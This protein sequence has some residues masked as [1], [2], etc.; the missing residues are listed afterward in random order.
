MV[1]NPN[2][3]ANGI[4]RSNRPQSL[5]LQLD[6][7]GSGSIQQFPEGRRDPAIPQ[8]LFTPP[9]SPGSGRLISTSQRN[10]EDSLQEEQQAI[11]GTE[12]APLEDS[13]MNA[14][15]PSETKVPL[16]VDYVPYHNDFDYEGLNVTGFDLSNLP[17]FP[18]R[19]YLYRCAFPLFVNKTLYQD[20]GIRDDSPLGAHFQLALTHGKSSPW[21]DYP[22]LQRPRGTRALREV[23]T[24]VWWDFAMMIRRYFHG[25][26]ASYITTESPYLLLPCT[27]FTSYGD[28]E[29]EFLSR[30]DSD[31]LFMK[32]ME[33][34]I[35]GTVSEVV[36]VMDNL[37]LDAPLV[38]GLKFQRQQVLSGEGNEKERWGVL[39][40]P[41]NIFSA[42]PLAV[43]C[44]PPWYL[45]KI[46]FDKVISK[47]VFATSPSGI[48]VLDTLDT[49]ETQVAGTS[50]LASN[51]RV[52]RDPDH[53][54]KKIWAVINDVCQNKGRFFILTNY[55]RWAFGQF[56]EDWTSVVISES[57]EPRLMQ[58]E[59]QGEFPGL[60]RGVTVPEAI[61]FWIQM[62][63]GTVAS[64]MI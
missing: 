24:Y 26:P 21:P 32:M 64:T 23:R 59:N 54:I 61:A 1:S 14:D 17:G 47:H 62:A 29:I 2:V 20:C 27:G 28:S 60:E 39:T 7:P 42:V 12:G 37:P 25:L 52:D 53:A 18:V 48:N 44:C 31:E 45:E 6:R 43:V 3:P 41:P 9:V 10:D 57:I 58:I 38:K 40:L 33:E 22:E 16:D 13:D 56:S 8:P 5:Q 49:D 55:T 35:L 11:R 36:R 63:R 15:S 19:L 30:I 34:H 46:Q 51:T 50:K 4:D